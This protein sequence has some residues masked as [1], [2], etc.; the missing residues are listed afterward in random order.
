MTTILWVHE[1]ALRSNHPAYSGFDL[2]TAGCF[3][4][5]DAYL[6]KMNYGRKRLVFI[7]ETVC[8]LNIPIYRG[9]TVSI[10]KEL[11]QNQGADEVRMAE[12]PNPELNKVARDLSEVMKVHVESD[13]S[14]VALEREPSLKRFFGY[15]KKARP[16]LLSE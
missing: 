5:D 13:E 9:D 10:L 11:A 12:T 6:Q 3:V 14:F 16:I 8:E 15:W 7:Y 2:A 4:W 1:D